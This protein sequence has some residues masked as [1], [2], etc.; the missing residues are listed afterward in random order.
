LRYYEKSYTYGTAVGTASANGLRHSS[1]L[2]AGTTG[3]LNHSLLFACHKRA[4][5]T[6]TIYD[7]AGNSGALSRGTFGVGETNN[8][9]ASVDVDTEKSAHIF[10]NTGDSHRVIYY[11]FQAV[12]EL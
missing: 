2:S 5:P 1:T 8:S 4:T 11:H 12:A 6:L 7:N 10:S 9:N 3:Y